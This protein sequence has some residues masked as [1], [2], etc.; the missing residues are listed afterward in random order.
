[1]KYLLSVF[2]LMMVHC[3]V[4][5]QNCKA[6]LQ[7]QD[8]IRYLACRVAEQRAG[9]DQY[10]KAYQDALDRALNICPEYAPGYALKS[11]AYLKSGDLIT[12]KYLIDQAVHWDPQSYLAYRAACRYQFFG[13]YHGALVDMALWDERYPGLD[14]FDPSGTYHI[15]LLR[16]FCWHAL[17]QHEKAFEL[18]GQRIARAG[19]QVGWYDHLH[20]GIMAYFCGK[21]E[22]SLEAL[23]KQSGIYN[24]AENQYYLAKIHFARREKSQAIE[25]LQKAD[26]LYRQGR[27]LKDPYTSMAHRIYLEDITRVIAEYSE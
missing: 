17:G 6:F 8:T 1:M 13:D 9:H 11:T 4:L 15:D 12:W 2:F 19:P 26:D 27:H 18:I 21:S 14:A 3:T 16:A 24:L 7:E 20:L 23:N 10:S 25:A 5:A 22:E